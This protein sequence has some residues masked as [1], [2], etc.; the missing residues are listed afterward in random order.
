MLRSIKSTQ[1]GPRML[2]F[3]ITGTGTAAINL[4]S[5]D[6]SLTDNGTGDYTLTFTKPFARIP[7][8]VA[9]SQT[10]GV[11]C[12]VIPAASS[13]EI[14]TKAR[15]NGAATDAVFDLIVLGFDSVDQF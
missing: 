9:S 7:V 13:I 3:K 2:A 5:G 6:A 8:A 14:L 10:A 4:N 15:S 12:E 11:Y 1:R